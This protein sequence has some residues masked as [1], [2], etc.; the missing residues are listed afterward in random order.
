[1][2][3]GFV[4]YIGS[5]KTT[6]SR[7][8]TA[9]R[10]DFQHIGFSDPM[11][12][13]MRA[14]GVPNDVIDDKALWNLPLEILCGQSLRYAMQ[15]LGTEWGRNCI[16]DDLWTNHAIN[17]VFNFRG[18][19]F[20]DNVRFPNEFTKIK[21]TGGILIAL[22]RQ[23]ATPHENERMHESEMYINELQQKCD[24]DLYNDGTIEQAVEGLSEII[25]TILYS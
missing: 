11:I 14:L 10:E 13:M 3:I 19:T 23:S 12:E 9:G 8:A 5:G 25:N 20:I 24:V 17:R 21:N 16:H 1:M 6:V 18:N 15:K 2:I 22:H 4:G 7:A